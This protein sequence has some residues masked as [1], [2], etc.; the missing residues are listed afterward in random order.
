MSNR[1]ALLIMSGLLA[2]VWAVTFWLDSMGI[3]HIWKFAFIVTYALFG[4]MLGALLFFLAKW[5]WPPTKEP[6]S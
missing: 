4:C 5:L 2:L 6:P 1:K 3:Q